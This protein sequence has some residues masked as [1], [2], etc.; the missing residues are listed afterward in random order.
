MLS[1]SACFVAVTSLFAMDNLTCIL[2]IILFCTGNRAFWCNQTSFFCNTCNTTKTVSAACFWYFG[3]LFCSCI[4]VLPCIFSLFILSLSTSTGNINR[5]FQYHSSSQSSQSKQSDSHHPA[6]HNFPMAYN[7]KQFMHDSA[8]LCPQHHFD[9]FFVCM[10]CCIAIVICLWSSH[11][12]SFHHSL[13]IVRGHLDAMNQQISLQYFPTL[14]KKH[15][16]YFVWMFYF[17]G[18][19]FALCS[20]TFYSFPCPLFYRHSNRQFQEYSSQS[21]IIKQVSGSNMNN[22]QGQSDINNDNN[23][24][25]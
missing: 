23:D 4:T 9:A 10:H 11:L 24:C 16:Q 3:L 25:K 17:C 22:M 8:K 12:Y 15:L 18:T 20:L 21:K 19:I 14:P 5:Q 1:L 2:F 6:L 13:Y 7:I